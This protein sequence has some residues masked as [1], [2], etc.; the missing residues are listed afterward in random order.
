MTAGAHYQINQATNS[1]TTGTVDVSRI[2]IRYGQQIH[3]IGDSASGQTIPTWTIIAWPFGSARGQPTGATTFDATYVPDVPGSYRVQFIVNDGIGV[4]SKIFI[5]AATRDGNGIIVDDSVREPAYGEAAGEDTVSGND[6]GWARSTEVAMATQIPIIT[7]VA[8]LLARRASKHKQVNLLGYYAAGDGGG[9]VLRWDAAS[10]QTHQPGVCFQPGFGTAGVVATGRWMRVDTG[11]LDALQLGCPAD[12]TGDDQPFLQ[13]F[14]DWAATQGTFGY[15]AKVRF[16][17]KPN[18]DRPRY[19]FDHTLTLPSSNLGFQERAFLQTIHLEGEV[20]QISDLSDVRIDYQ[21][22]IGGTCIDIVGGNG[23][24][25]SNLDIELNGRAKYGMW[26][27]PDQTMPAETGTENIYVE[28]VQIR[29]PQQAAGAS[30]VVMGPPVSGNPFTQASEIRFTHCRLIGD[31]SNGSSITHGFVN[32]T[33]GNAKNIS[34]DGG[35]FSGHGYAVVTGNSVMEFS[36]GVTFGSNNLACFLHSSG[37]LHCKGI[38]IESNYPNCK[39]MDCVDIGST[40]GSAT[41]ETCELNYND[42]QIIDGGGSNDI[43]L[44][45]YAGRLEFN[46]C[47]LRND[48]KS[49][50][51]SAT[52]NGV[53][54]VCTKVSH[55]LRTG[56]RV[57]ILGALGNTAMNVTAGVMWKINVLTAN[58]YALLHLDGTAVV[59]NGTYTGGAQVQYEPQIVINQGTPPYPYGVSSRGN[60]WAFVAD[61]DSLP[62]FRNGDFLRLGDPAV[63]QTISY[64]VSSEGDRGFP[65]VGGLAYRIPGYNCDIPKFPHLTAGTVIADANGVLTTTAGA[66]SGTVPTGRTITAGAGLTGGGDFTANR[67]LDIVAADSTIV[68]NADSIQIG[69]GIAVAKLTPGSNGQALVVSGGVV[70]WGAPSGGSVTLAGDVTGAS[71]GNIVEKLTGTGGVVTIPVGT[72]LTYASGG[73][74]MGQRPATTDW[75]AKVNTA[76]ANFTFYDNTNLVAYMTWAGGANLFSP[77]G[78]S[79]RLI[80]SGSTQI[81][82]SG[83]A[84]ILLS[85]DNLRFQDSAG[86]ARGKWVAAGLRIGDNAISTHPLEVAGNTFLEGTVLFKANVGSLQIGQQASTTGAGFD[87]QLSAQAALSSSGGAG[88]SLLLIGGTPDGAGTAGTVQ[89]RPGGTT[90]LTAD[91]T[92]LIVAKSFITFASAVISPLIRQADAVSAN[93]QPLQISAQAGNGTNKNGGP[94][95]L[96]DGAL[97]GSGLPGG[98]FTFSQGTSVITATAAGVSILGGGTFAT[99]ALEVTGDVFLNGAIQR[100]ISVGP[101]TATA[102][103]RALNVVAGGGAGSNQDGGTL[104]L[105][106][107]PETGTGI[108]GNVSLL[109]GDSGGVAMVTAHALA[110]G[111]RRIVSLCGVATTTTCPSGDKVVWIGPNVFTPVTQPTN[112]LVLASSNGIWMWGSNTGALPL[113]LMNT[114]GGA[115]TYGLTSTNS[116]NIFLNGTGY[117]IP[118][119]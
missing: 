55:G 42:G 23:I 74:S 53:P 36:N 24:I 112:G 44:I 77:Q 31:I 20:S 4:N 89:L 37:H 60:T 115:V 65:L 113:E 34:F 9:Q 95:Y 49:S 80:S 75:M 40:D 6:R 87:F 84:D 92:G 21:G 107:G 93:G 78:T 106:G 104:F 11:P 26:L 50:I 7:N 82:P 45:Y 99:H 96:T 94:L 119:V 54:I 83:N 72:L 118:L 58:T 27:R 56:D 14:F 2:D 116:L 38:D 108:G 17:R 79:F 88:G 47:I 63:A 62:V 114:L 48:R 57:G 33:G 110:H 117:R 13:T 59:G 32:L 25:I 70:V 22:P 98:V 101:A 15:S 19:R 52:G 41:F 76:N 69:S 30:C 39:W 81:N 90:V 86:S 5:F 71:G 85:S 51:T 10:T 35:T 111:T 29:H 105:V 68:V 66:P 73:P 61:G 91:L 103:G 46:N 3:L 67:T 97:T 16:S 64:A 102:A 1:P 100:T 109:C 28:H 43:V 8:A 18:T 12:G